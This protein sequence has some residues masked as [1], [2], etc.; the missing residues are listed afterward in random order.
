MTAITLTERTKEKK[1]GVVWIAAELNILLTK[2][3]R[4]NG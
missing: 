2:R 1:M 4:R 3:E